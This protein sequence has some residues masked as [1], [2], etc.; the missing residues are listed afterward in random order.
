MDSPLPPSHLPYTDKYFIR[1]KRILTQEGMNPDVSVQVFIRQ[2][3][4]AAYGLDEAVAILDRYAGGR[5]RV[6]ALPE[7]AAYAPG[8]TVLRIEGRIQDIVE[9][10]TMYLGVITSRTSERNDGA[11]IDLDRVRRHATLIRSLLPGKQLIYFGARHWHWSWDEAICRTVM[12][13][14]FDGCATD[15][16]ACAAGLPEGSGTIPHALVLVF[17]HYHGRALATREATLAF[18]R[19]IEPRAPR[20][21][22]IDTFSREMDDAVDTARALGPKL[23]GG[24]H[25]HGRRGHRPGRRSL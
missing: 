5:C 4:G 24:A 2:G 23:W 20:I 18:D 21:A 1:T 8:D 17:A 7:G 16:G 9:L 10:E 12:D 11:A 22:L 6:W 14:G 25:R 3:P 13:A 19:H 15:I